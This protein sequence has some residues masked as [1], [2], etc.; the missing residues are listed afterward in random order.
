MGQI[1]ADAD[2]ELEVALGSDG[3]NNV[4]PAIT[5]NVS[6]GGRDCICI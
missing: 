1:E 2:W 4:D 6:Y 5:R 3:W